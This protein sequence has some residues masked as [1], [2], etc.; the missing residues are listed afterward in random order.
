VTDTLS[1][2]VVEGFPDSYTEQQAWHFVRGAH[3]WLLDKVERLAANAG[4]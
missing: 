4:A 3:G 2:E 1:G